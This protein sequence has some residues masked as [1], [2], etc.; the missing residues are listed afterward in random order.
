ME[1][2]WQIR[3]VLTNI[4]QL[5]DERGFISVGELSELLHVSEMTIRRYWS[6]W[7]GKVA[8]S[9]PMA[10]QPRSVPGSERMEMAMMP[11]RLNSGQCPCWNASM[12]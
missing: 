4:I 1:E 3:D 6:N 9:V 10:A 5:V 2:L 12:S 8:C 7:M 11:P